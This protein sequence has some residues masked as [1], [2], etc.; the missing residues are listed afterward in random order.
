M[1][2]ERCSGRG[3][4][5]GVQWGTF[6][7]L[8]PVGDIQR[9]IC[10]G[11]RCSGGHSPTQQVSAPPLWPVCQLSLPPWPRPPQGGAWLP[12]GATRR[13]QPEPWRTCRAWTLPHHTQPREQA[14]SP[15]AGGLPGP[16]AKVSEDAGPGGLAGVVGGAG[17][18]GQRRRAGSSSARGSEPEMQTRGQSHRPCAQHSQAGQRGQAGG[19]REDELGRRHTHTPSLLGKAR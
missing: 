7:G 10:S 14:S 18:E 4:V 9:E 8:C 17:C 3:A 13:L 5:R 11:G 1:Q 19:C 15:L 2:R 6:S 12:L 16:A